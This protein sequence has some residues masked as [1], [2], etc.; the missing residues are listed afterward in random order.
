MNISHFFAQIKRALRLY[1]GRRLTRQ[2]AGEIDALRMQMVLMRNE[3]ER[4]EDKKRRVN[5]EM[6]ELEVPA[7]VAR[8]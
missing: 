7:S 8:A 1:R 3:I 6:Q 5:R 2:I 4:L